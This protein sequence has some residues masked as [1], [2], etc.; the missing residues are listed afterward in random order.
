TSHSTSSSFRKTEAEI[1]ERRKFLDELRGTLIG[2]LLSDLAVEAWSAGSETDSWFSGSLGND[3]ILYKERMEAE[4]AE[5]QRAAARKLQRKKSAKSIR[6]SARQ[7]NVQ[8]AN[9]PG[10]LDSRVSKAEPAKP[11]GTYQNVG[12]DHPY[13]HSGEENSSASDA[14]ARSA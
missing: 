13:H 14:T 9:R 2:L 3:C 12:S 10:V 5:R 4:A 11:I 7:Q 8:A 1:T 6:S